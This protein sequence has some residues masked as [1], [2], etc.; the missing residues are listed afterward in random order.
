MNIKIKTTALSLTPSISEYIEKR[1]SPVEKFFENDSTIICDIEIAKT[2][3]HHKNG[4]IFRAEVHIVA[5]DRN[6]YASSEKEDLYIAI[7]AVKDE[8]LR[9]VKST[10]ARQRSLI[11][12]GSAKIKELIKGIGRNKN[13]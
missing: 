2:T 5:K 12:R 3:N 6:I 13:A 10:N 11:R 4:D 7:D 1:I 9:E 8:V